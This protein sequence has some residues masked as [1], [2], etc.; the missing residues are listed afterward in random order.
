MNAEIRKAVQQEDLHSRF[1]AQGVELV[2]SES[3]EQFTSFLKTQ[4]EKY[5]QV[6]KKARSGSATAACSSIREPLFLHRCKP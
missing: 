6:V 3:P 1:A 2:A 5:I 4:S